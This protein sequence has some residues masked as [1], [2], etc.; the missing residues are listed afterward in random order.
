MPT[1]GQSASDMRFSKRMAAMVFKKPSEMRVQGG[2]SIRRG[3]TAA[4]GNS[5]TLGFL[6]TMAAIR[7]EN[8]SKMP[9]SA[10]RVTERAHS[11]A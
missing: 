4:A 7:L 11:A 3:L 10:P 2:V 5:P 9:L 6:K 8:A 1:G